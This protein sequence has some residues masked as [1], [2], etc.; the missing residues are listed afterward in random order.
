MEYKLTFKDYNQALKENKLLG[1]KCKRCSTVTVPP[2]MVCRKC[3]S[4]DMEVVEL[5]GKGKIQTFTTCNV[6]PEGREGEV[7]YVILLVELDE[8]PWIMGNLTGIDPKTTTVEL[9]G[10]R[11]KMGE[12]K[13]FS[14]DKYSAGEGA[15]P[16]FGLET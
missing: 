9:I 10:K 13:V 15:R 4:P 3:T 16:I 11:V 14:G 12:S 2:K 8:G 6:A 5:T 7:P 1:L